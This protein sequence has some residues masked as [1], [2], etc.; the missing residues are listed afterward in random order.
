MT[1]ARAGQY[2]AV[3]LLLQHKPEVAR[4]NHWRK[5]ALQVAKEHG[6]THI[7]KLI[8]AYQDSLPSS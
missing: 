7:V 6:H 1:A 5:T 4:L 8:K 3:K 2:D